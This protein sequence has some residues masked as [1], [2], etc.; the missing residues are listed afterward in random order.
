M[1]DFF[2]GL[3]HFAAAHGA[4]AAPLVF[5]LAFA[6]SLAF[7]S[8]V[9][10][11]WGALVG[12]GTLLEPSGLSFWP[13]WIAGSLGAAAGD[14]VSY[15]AGFR[16]RS[17]IAR[18]WPLSRNPELLPRGH[19]FVERW[20]VAAVVVGRF[21]GPLRASVPLVCGVLEMP[22]LRFQAAN[23]A[24][25]FVWVAVLLLFGEGIGRG[26]LHFLS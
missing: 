3:V 1:R 17:G 5:V 2:R 21:S 18:M 25:A 4:W 13:I 12:I 10:P 11:A 15:W 23:F 6:E 14:W 9:V 24:S 19:Q 16:F 8:L 22:R 26:V 20:G 7:L